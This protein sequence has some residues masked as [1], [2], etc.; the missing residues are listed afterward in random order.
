MTTARPPRPRVTLADLLEA[1]LLDAPVQISSQYRG[2][3]FRAWVLED[4]SV[5]FRGRVY[6]ARRRGQSPLSR[7][8]GLAM[9]EVREAPPG[10]DLPTADGWFFWKV[11]GRRIAHLRSRFLANRSWDQ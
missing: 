7:I 9:S 1:G 4:G 3:R 8:A 11:E 2:K 5:K 10:R 6:Q